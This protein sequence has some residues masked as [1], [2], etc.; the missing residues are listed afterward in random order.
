MTLTRLALGL[1]VAAVLVACGPALLALGT[2]TGTT[3]R[4]LGGLLGGFAPAGVAALLLLVLPL[5]LGGTGWR[6]GTHR[7]AAGAFVGGCAVAVVA[8]TLLVARYDHLLTAGATAGL[9]G[10]AV[11]LLAAASTTAAAA[12]AR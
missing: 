10:A 5:W 8:G 3:R 6:A 4:L 7:G 2:G 9:L 12:A 1:R 11:V